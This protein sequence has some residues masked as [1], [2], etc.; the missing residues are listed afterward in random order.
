V[1][2]SQQSTK[3]V[4]PLP[5]WVYPT[6]TVLIS[7]IAAVVRVVIT[8]RFYY[9]DDT[10]NGAFGIWYELGERLLSGRWSILNPQVWQGGNYLAEGQWG[11]FNPLTL[12]FGLGTQAIDDVVLYV[13]I[14]KIALLAAMALGVYLLSR[15]FGAHP[16]WSVVAGVAAPLAG[17]TM[18]MDAPSWVTGLVNSALIPFAWWALR[19]TLNEKK[20]PLPFLI[21]AYLLITAGYIFGV[22]ILAVILGVT[23]LE[24][25]MSK[26]RDNIRL[27]LIASV[28]SGLVTIAIYLPGILTAP[29]TSRG[30]FSVRNDYFLNADINDLLAAAV[31]SSTVSIQGWWGVVA[32]VPLQYVAWFLPL[33][34]LVLPMTKEATRKLVPL[35]V[36][37]GISLLLVL[38][39]SAIGPIR[40]P[41]RMMPYV[42][43]S[44][45]VIFAVAAS[46]RYPATLSWKR[47]L[48]VGG[49]AAGSTWFAFVEVPRTGFQLAAFFVG[50]AIALLALR[51]VST[52]AFAQRA[53]EWRHD[54][55]AGVIVLTTLALVVPQALVD[56]SS[57]LGDFGVP[58]SISEMKRPLGQAEND[59]LVVGDVQAMGTMPNYQET[60]VANL[61][62]VND[63]NVM[64]VY[65]VLQFNGFS[66]EL[67]MDWRGST[68]PELFSALFVPDEQTGVLLVDLLSINSLLVL[69]MDGT[70]DAPAEPSGWSLRETGEYSYLYV[71]DDLVAPAGGVVWQSDGLE[72]TTVD[73]SETSVTL[74]VDKVPSDGGQIALSRLAWPGYSIDNGEF[75]DPVRGYLL[76]A[77]IDADAAGKTVE[78]SFRPPGWALEL[79]SFVIAM[80]IAIV[81]P[82]MHVRKRRKQRVALNA[83]A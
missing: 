7:V 5:L 47:L 45:L 26:D 52:L 32:P 81:W 77:H 13:T 76:S 24:A 72:V 28:F 43:I 44:A 55:A 27:S 14:V 35:L 11:L 39:P 71:R 64:N 73:T 10:Q 4:V 61:W 16:A 74:R 21:F 31:P 49:V 57:P 58:S 75:V 6:I 53:P 2:E 63:H 48:L 18:Y 67:C 62:Y 36:V 79:A 70:V 65:S 1:A 59:V 51:W 50:I 41:V 19:R 37:L 38:G 83:E 17:F 82:V 15:S 25:L 40:F 80:A 3:P 9:F 12:L 42:V 20:S 60:L 54:L 23:L 8:P 78:I 29:V 30:G 68:C 56:R 66:S 46:H 22:M 33:F 69:N 34:V